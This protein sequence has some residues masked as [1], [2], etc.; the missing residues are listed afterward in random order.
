[1]KHLLASLLILSFALVAKAQG[2]DE[3]IPCRAK[4]LESCVCFFG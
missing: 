4:K 2:D 1:M 3:L